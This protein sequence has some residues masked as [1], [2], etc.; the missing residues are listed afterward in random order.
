MKQDIFYITM[1]GSYE[2]N[3]WFPFF[4]FEDAKKYLLE[5]I[6]EKDKYIE[7]ELNDTN[8]LYYITTEKQYEFQRGRDYYIE[9]L[10]N[11]EIINF[12]YAE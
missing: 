10:D 12:G 1:Y 9:K 11:D 6:I 2:N 8:A 7:N 3:I 4:S 5:R